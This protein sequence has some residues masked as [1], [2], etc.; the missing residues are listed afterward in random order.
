MPDGEYCIEYKLLGAPSMYP[1]YTVLNWGQGI[2]LPAYSQAKMPSTN[3]PNLSVAAGGAA[4]GAGNDQ[5]TA[6]DKNF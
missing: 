1:G 5:R 2:A 3:I 6:E 4:G